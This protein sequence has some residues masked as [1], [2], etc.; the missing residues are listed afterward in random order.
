MN[1]GTTVQSNGQAGKF[2]KITPTLKGISPHYLGLV[3]ILTVG[4]VLRFWSLDAKPLWMDEVLTAIFSLGRRYADVPV[5]TLFSIADLNQFFT[6]QPGVSCPQISQTVATESVHPPLF[7]CLLHSWIAWLQSGDSNW[8]WTLRAFPALTGVGAIAALY[9]LN[10]IAFSPAA[11]LLGAALMAVSPFTV[12]LSQEARHYTLPM[13]LISLALV[14]LVQL[15]QDVQTRRIRPLV[16][17]GWVLV[18]VVSLYVHY[19][20]ILALIAQITVLLLWMLWK[21]RQIHSRYWIATGLAIAAIALAYLPWLPTVIGHFSR[22]ETDWLIP[23][24]PTWTTRLAPLY[25]TLTAWVLM[26]IALP[27]ETQPLAIAVPSVLVMLVFSVWFVWQ[28][29]QGCKWL[30]RDRS[31]RP[32]AVLISGFTLCVLVQFFAI[33]YLLNKDI[34]VVPRYNFVYYP[35]VCALL[36]ACL[37]AQP[38]RDE[39]QPRTN[40]RICAVLLAGLISSGCVVTDLVFQKPYNPAE[41]AETMLLE[42]STPMI[43]ATSYRT[44]QEIALGFSFALELRTRY[45]AS[46]QAPVRFAFFDRRQGTAMVWRSLAALSQPLPVPLNLW[47][48]APEIRKRD[49]PKQLKVSLPSGSTEKAICRLDPEEFHRL[50]FPY[51]LYRCE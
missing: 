47:I 39:K 22:P 50:G 38:K 20:C 34:T 23:R 13:L 33:V 7:F 9:L 8:I 10:R 43:M 42:P 45:P 49:Y 35:G 31:M 27:V 18:N 26:V 25:Q 14:G 2:P 17:L 5:Q 4:T 24:D 29:S 1:G 48:V 15:Q 16:W 46:A 37:M 36:G 19:F 11:G 51:Q 40:L 21:R 28:I 6:V 30:W 12:Y 41:V 32:S 3:V 44:L